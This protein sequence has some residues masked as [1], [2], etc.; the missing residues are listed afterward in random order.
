MTH[1]HT[2][3][4]NFERQQHNGITLFK[5]YDDFLKFLTII[6]NALG[7]SESMLKDD[8]SRTSR[9]HT[10]LETVAI[11]NSIGRH[12]YLLNLIVGSFF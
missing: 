5:F 4:D 3:L 1:T 6:L 10:F 9:V 8:I 12:F 7:K 11:W 2:Q